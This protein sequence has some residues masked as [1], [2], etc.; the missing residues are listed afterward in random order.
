MSDALS[1]E[2]VNRIRDEKIVYGYVRSNFITNEN[3]IPRDIINLCLTFYHIIIRE[4]FKHYNPRN[5]DLSNDDMTVTGAV[6]GSWS[7]CYGSQCIPSS[8]TCTYS[9][10]FKVK[11]M[12]TYIAIGID[13]TKYIRKHTG[14]FNDE[15]SGK[16]KSYALWNNQQKN[17]WDHD[18][19]IDAESVAPKFDTNDVVRMILDLQN[20]TLSYQVNEGE[21]YVAFK[22]ISVGAHIEYCMAVDVS[23]CSGDCVELLACELSQ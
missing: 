14:H 16:T 13:E 10:K 23:T 9:W 6:A 18:G 20:R 11:K 22:G 4:T 17:Q 21:I 19:L 3:H 15:K 1:I 5:Y 7:I 8:D 2:E 12:A